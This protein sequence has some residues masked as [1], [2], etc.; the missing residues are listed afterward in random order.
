MYTHPEQNIQ[1]IWDNLKRYT[2]N[3]IWIEELSRKNIRGKNDQGFP[4]VLRDSKPQRI[5][6]SNKIF[7]KKKSPHSG[8]SYLNCRKPKTNRKSWKK[9]EEATSKTSYIQKK[10]EELQE[11]SHQ[12]PHNQEESEVKCF[13]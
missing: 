3:E 2:L 1:E 6:K 13:K 11:A 4:K 12:N 10:E 9:S 8:I 5:R 7:K